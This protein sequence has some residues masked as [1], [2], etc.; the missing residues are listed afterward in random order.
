MKIIFII[1]VFVQ[2]TQAA[3]TSKEAFDILRKNGRVGIGGKSGRIEEGSTRSG[4]I[5]ALKSTTVFEVKE[6]ETHTMSEVINFL[7]TAIKEHH[8]KINVII[9]STLGQANPNIAVIPPVIQIDPLTG[10]PIPPMFPL[11]NANINTFNPDDIKIVGLKNKLRN[12]NFL[13]LIELVAQSFDTPVQYAIT[14]YGVVF[15]AKP[16]DQAEFFTRQFRVNLEPVLKNQR[17]N[18]PNTPRLGIGI[19]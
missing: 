3:L 12:L 13:Q 19:K 14:D 7:D 4:V 10:L 2:V 11:Q 1:L 9:N 17:L 8:P 18:I 6:L 5:S 16:A 15:F